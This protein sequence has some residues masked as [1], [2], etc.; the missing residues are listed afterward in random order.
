MHDHISLI[1]FFKKN[2]NAFKKNKKNQFS[3]ISNFFQILESL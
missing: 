3:Y 1:I 2:C